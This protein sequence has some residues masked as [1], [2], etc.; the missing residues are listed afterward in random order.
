[1]SGPEQASERAE[2]LQ[3]A[4]QAKKAG[5]RARGVDLAARPADQPAA[6]GEMQRGLWVVHQLDPGSSAYNLCSAFRVRGVL[7]VPRLQR[8]F[9]HV[10]SRHRLLRST[11]QA[12]GDTARQVIHAAAALTIERVEAED[13]SALVVATREAR[14]PFDLAH[15]PLVRVQ[16]IDESSGQT[17]VLLLTVHHILADERSLAFL[18]KEVA[19]AYAGRLADTV[20]AAQYDDYVH[21]IEHAGASRRDEDLAFWRERLDPQPDDLRLPFEQPASAGSA[22]GRLIERR[23]RASV[24]AGIRRLATATG[25]TPF[26]VYAFVFRLLL[27]RYTHGQRVAFAT[28]VTTRSHPAAAEM[29]GYF[30]NPLVV[31]MPLDEQQQVG[32]CVEQFCTELKALLAHASLPFDV[33]AAA[34]APARQADRHPLFQV[35]FVYQESDP[36]PRL[37]EVALEPI[38]LDLGAAKFDLTLLVSESD[39]G[40]QLAVEFRADR[41]DALWMEALLD[42]YETLLEHL[43]ADRDR[44]VREVPMLGVAELQRVS[45]WERGPQLDGPA[46]ELLPPQML[47]QARRQP[48]EAAVTCG[49]V[50]LRYEQLE[51]AGRTIAAALRAEGV[52]PGDRV[53]LFLPR[54][55]QMIAGVVGSHLAGAAYVP[56]DPSYPEARNRDVLADAGVATVLT[57]TALAGRLPA[58]PWRSMAV[59]AL[60]P[61]AAR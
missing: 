56:L 61:D 13:G 40:L 22:E 57:T 7:D 21:W 10:V 38:T 4:I 45:A 53:A 51:T 60:Q 27:H 44:P 58:G 11:F 36:T 20:P 59:D 14:R 48:Q 49:G 24:Q 41:F 43:P 26:M 34:L 23:P 3:R 6:L 1:M 55:T 32:P 50:S 39:G 42:H 8:A 30:L 52:K 18:W 25:A 12:D 33:L 17:R 46:M 47:A 54:S 31:A 9:T 15:G 2:R 19:E 28:P 16:L 37:G 5:A 35:M 29:I